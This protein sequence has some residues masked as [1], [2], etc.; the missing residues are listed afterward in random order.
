MTRFLP[1][2]VSPRP[3]GGRRGLLLPPLRCSLPPGTPASGCRRR[4]RLA[5]VLPLPRAAAT[6]SPPPVFPAVLGRPSHS[7]LGPLPHPHSTAVVTVVQPLFRPL[8]LLPPSPSQL[9]AGVLSFR[10][11]P[12]HS[13]FWR[14]LLSQLLCIYSASQL[15]P[16]PLRLLFAI[17]LVLS[18]HSLQRSWQSFP[19][20]P[21]IAGGRGCAVCRDGRRL[22]E[23]GGRVVKLAATAGCPAEGAR[24]WHQS[25]GGWDAAAL[26]VTVGGPLRGGCFGHRLKVARFDSS[27]NCLI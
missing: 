19:A 27:R 2:V 15:R 5:H 21:A 25:A 12:H 1:P 22:D 11:C 13:L 4:W 7:I 17:P 20:D 8:P 6:Q 14:P 3:V 18:A 24:R 16:L 26:P 9:G 23:S 10:R